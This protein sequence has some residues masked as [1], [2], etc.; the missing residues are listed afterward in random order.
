[1]NGYEPFPIY[2]FRSGL[3]LNK[4]PWLIPSD[5]FKKMKNAFIYQGVLQ[6]RKGRTE[7]G[8]FVHAVAAEALGTTVDEQLTYTG[9]HL[10]H[11][12]LR[13]GDLLI[14]TAG[15]GEHFDDDGDGTLTG[16]AGGTGTID[17]TTGAWSI[18]Y[19]SNPGPGHDI[20]ADYDYFPNL[21]IMGIHTYYQDVGTQESLVF[22]T[23]RINKYNPTPG[24]EK[25]EDLTGSDIFTGS[26]SDFF[27]FENW[28]DRLF[29]TNNVDRVKVYDGADLT[30][31]LIDTDGDTNNDVNTCLLIFAYKGH[32][33]LLRTKE[34]DPSV[35][36]PHRARWSVSN[37]YAN[38]KESEGGGFVDCPS[39]DWIMGADFIGDD[40]IIGMERSIWT[41]KYIG[42]P[43]LPFRWENIKGTEGCYGT[44]S[45]CPFSDELIMLAAT[46][47]VA[48]DGID[49]DGIDDKI[50]DFALNFN[51]AGF[52]YC[53]GIVLEETR[54]L[55]LTYPSVGAEHP[56][57]VLVMNYEEATFADFA[58]SLHCLGYYEEAEDLILDDIDIDIDTLE[59]S[60][61]DKELQAGYP[62]TLGGSYDGYLYQLNN[63]GN[64]NGE[65][66]DFEVESAHWNPYLK[67]GNKAR[68]G[69]IDFLI[70][71][72]PNI[73]F[74]VD[75]Y[76]GES[77]SPYQTKTILCDGEGEK[78]WKR[79][80]SGAI[81]TFH[82][83]RIHGNAINQTPKIHCVTP[84][85]A[86]AGR[87]I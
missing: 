42:D 83:I 67:Q 30:D 77:L 58:M 36:C 44:F 41:L 74:D 22:N 78:V 10:D 21:P 9:D 46:R 19:N 63:G 7:W 55:W 29:I 25:L 13:P 27:W 54:M 38:W 4:Q 28:K 86:P 17:Y 62:I 71:R 61:D 79:V 20:T 37:S 11:L 70:D 39:I 59:Y 34:A 56:D 5:A 45:V 72:D 23:K 64:D 75:F 69:F 66:I 24:I 1:M 26:D 73:S 35:H 84:W 65:A 43:L 76:S 40:L 16:S 12:P 49:I 33:V 68:L 14:E 6:K 87:M 52:K 82:R 2:D 15:P 50:P 18:T 80:Y 85:F 81:G 51:Q 31:L 60:F 48:T 53:Y 47:M 8:R 32:L 57:K 3:T